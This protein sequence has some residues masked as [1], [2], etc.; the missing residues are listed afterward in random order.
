MHH[1]HANTLYIQDEEDRVTPLKEALLVKEDK[2]PNIRFVFTKGLGHRK[3]YKDADTMAR[4]VA[5]L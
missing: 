1:V 3:V 5:F 2:H 4:I